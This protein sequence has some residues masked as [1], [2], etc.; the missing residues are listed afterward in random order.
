MNHLFVVHYKLQN[1]FLDIMPESGS[2]EWNLLLVNTIFPLEFLY[3]KS[4]QQ[5]FSLLRTF[6]RCI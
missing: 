3:A 1:C 2:G 4:P 6:L 5:I